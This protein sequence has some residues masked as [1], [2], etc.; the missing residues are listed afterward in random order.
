MS[1][2]VAIATR[3]V[4]LHFSLLPKT[5]KSFRV[6]LERPARV[7]FPFSNTALRNTLKDTPKGY[8]QLAQVPFIEV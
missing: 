4:A 1:E 2:N 7:R 5:S 6:C 3:V 8:L